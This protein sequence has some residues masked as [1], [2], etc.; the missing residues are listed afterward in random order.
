MSKIDD[1]EKIQE[2]K[3]KGILTEEEFE[4]EKNKILGYTKK[5]DVPDDLKKIEELRSKGTLTE[6]EFEIEKQ[7]ILGIS[8]N[9]ISEKSIVNKEIE[10]ENI[11][12]ED[13]LIN[14]KKTKKIIYIVPIIILVIISVITAFIVANNDDTN[15]KQEIGND[16]IDST[17]DNEI[18]ENTEEIVIDEMV[19]KSNYKYN[20]KDNN[21]VY[22][23]LLFENNQFEICSILENT[24]I[25][26]RGDYL[27]N[28]E[29]ISLNAIKTI[30][31]VEIE[32]QNIVSEEKINVTLTGYLSNNGNTISVV[33]EEG[34]T[35][36]F[37]LSEQ[38]GTIEEIKGQIYEENSKETTSSETTTS[39]SS[40]DT[41]KTDINTNTNAS[42]PKKEMVEVPWFSYL[43]EPLEYYTSK[44][45]NAGIS[46]K[47]VKVENLN[48][49]NNSVIEIEHNGEKIEK[50]TTITITI[51]D[52]SNHLYDMEIWVNTRYLLD[53]AG[54]DYLDYVDSK[55]SLSIKINGTNI[56]NGKFDRETYPT[57]PIQ[58]GNY[59]GKKDNLKF[60]ITIEGK[61]ITQTVNYIFSEGLYSDKPA[62]VIYQGGDM[63]PLG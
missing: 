1:L 6:E 20:G 58:V 61:K 49:E 45:K 11:S 48:Y 63:G 46:Y 9:I 57:S 12:V 27:T 18:D 54:L 52:N 37:E 47:I 25:F 41:N 4:N 62:I 50:G 3:S 34:E 2:L 32:G 24:K 7:K 14:N 39:S 19:I 30:T 5:K 8:D 29:V 31:T 43:G 53:L 13:P 10:T 59:K 55:V 26:I 21:E 16:I 35:V 28:R 38:V 22:G 36:V 15:P 44:L 60:D 33:S 40:A 42:Q 51:A 17:L 23:Y 56:C